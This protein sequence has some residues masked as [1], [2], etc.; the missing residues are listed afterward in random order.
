MC[1]WRNSTLFPQSFRWN[2]IC[3]RVKMNKRKNVRSG[4]TKINSMKEIHK[5]ERFVVFDPRRYQTSR[6]QATFGRT[7]LSKRELILIWTPKTVNIL[8]AIT[9]STTTVNMGEEAAK[10]SKSFFRKTLLGGFLRQSV[11]LNP[12]STKQE[13]FQ[14]FWN[15]SYFWRPSPPYKAPP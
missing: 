12:P 13:E 15:H 9:T 8:S 5:L 7:D 14:P 3:S 2:S 6:F 11:H 10:P 4:W 1:T